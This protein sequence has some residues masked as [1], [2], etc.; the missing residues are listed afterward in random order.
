[1]S[2]VTRTASDP[3][4]AESGASHDTAFDAAGHEGSSRDGDTDGDRE[5]RPVLSVRGSLFMDPLTW[6]RLGGFVMQ[7][8][9]LFRKA[10][11][12]EAARRANVAARLVEDCVTLVTAKKAVLTAA[13]TSA[14]A[15]NLALQESRKSSQDNIAH[16]AHV[17][18]LMYKHGQAQLH[19]SQAE[20]AVL[21][22]ETMMIAVKKQGAEADKRAEEAMS[23]W[24]AAEVGQ[25]PC[26]F[27]NQAV[28]FEDMLRH[29][30]ATEVGK[31]AILPTCFSFSFVLL[32]L[33][34]RRPCLPPLCVVW[35]G[36]GVR[37]ADAVHGEAVHVKS[38]A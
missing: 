33:R 10:E 31:G 5:V 34:M 22:A 19:V 12:R 11:V 16:G 2:R 37:K 27:F 15:V 20:E 7:S 26:L 24:R 3:E 35:G 25:P 13:V 4:L 9:V 30:L 18:W 29:A 23:A 17:G 38:Q 32:L 28:Y 8:E 21:A 1:M 6:V 14:G 36:G